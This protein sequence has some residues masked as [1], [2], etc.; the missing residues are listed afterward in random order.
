MQA[1]ILA[2]SETD[3]LRPLTETL[4][5]AML[6]VLSRPVMV[7]AIEQLAQQGIKNVVVSLYHMPGNVEAYFGTGQRWNLSIEYVLQREQWGSAGDL[8]WAENL[9]TETFLALPAGQVFELDIQALWEWHKAHQSQAT[10]IIHPRGVGPGV[11]VAASG[12]VTAIHPGASAPPSTMFSTGIY[13]FERQILQSIPARTEWDIFTDLLPHLI[14]RGVSVYGYPLAEFWHPIRSFRDYQA[15]HWSYLEHLEAGNQD[16]HRPVRP[17]IPLRARAVARGIWVGR[18]TLIHPAARLS[19]PVFIGEN[20]F[21]G[22]DVELGPE[23]MIGSNVLVDDGATISHSTVLDSTYIGQFVH[24]KNNVASAGLLIDI[25]T[26]K[27][28]QVVD[29]FLLGEVRTFG[30][31]NFLQRLP[32]RMITFLLLVGLSPFLFLLGLIAWLSTGRLFSTV[33]RVGIRTSTSLTTDGTE[34]LRNFRLFRFSTRRANG[35]YSGLGK[36]L[37]R[38]EFYRLPELWNVL[39]GD[40]R[41]IGVKSLSPDEAGKIIEKWQQKR[42][43]YPPGFTGLWYAQTTPEST[44]DEIL[45]SDAYYVATRTWREDMRILWQTLLVWWKRAGKRPS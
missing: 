13:L 4:P 12:Q 25:E 1:I 3:G 29:Q 19:P 7:G 15:A 35:K 44:L 43:E 23:A 11:S 30:S 38:W 8:K 40:L 17:D 26:G 24:V 33:M 45:I 2:T 21:I 18:N 37:E 36:W 14:Q 28:I 20:S 31:E 5:T 32:D 10:M 42:N 22:R 39:I 6:P 9:L 41:L 27:S 34:Q 16:G